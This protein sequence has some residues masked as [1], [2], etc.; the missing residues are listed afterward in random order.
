MSLSELLPST[1]STVATLPLPVGPWGADEAL[2]ALA[3]ARDALPLALGDATVVSALTTVVLH[4]AEYAVKVYPPGTD[5]SHLDRLT[6]ALA[7]S[8]SAHL[9]LCA[10][11]V[12]TQGVVTVAPWLTD[13]RP[14]T[15]AHLGSL[16]RTFHE[17]HATADVPAWTPLSRLASQVDGLPEEAAEVLLGARDAL[18]A[19]VEEI[20]S[21]LGEGTIHGDVSPSNV[22]RSPD[23]PRLIDLDWV[24][25]APREYDLSSASRRVADGEISAA[26]YAQFCAAYDFDV[27]SWPGLPLLNRIADLGGVAFRLW[28]SR[29]HGVDLDWIEQE[30]RV[31]RTPL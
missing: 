27:R 15:W 14:V 11:V 13:T 19:A 31:W 10:P 28:D 23:G 21:E 24:G 4:C 30:V 20:D 12:T 5:A 1:V 17:E 8:R 29:H 3:E 9:P 16:L 2:A 7:G 25:R 22:M 18:L 26:T 6:G